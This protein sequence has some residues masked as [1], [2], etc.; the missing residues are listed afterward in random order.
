MRSSRY[1]TC[2]EYR[3]PHPIHCS[4]K[5][6]GHFF[7]LSDESQR[8][9]SAEDSESEATHCYSVQTRLVVVE[10]PR[11]WRSEPRASSSTE[12]VCERIA[13]REAFILA[14]EKRN[15]LL[16][17]VKDT[18]LSCFPSCELLTQFPLDSET[19]SAPAS[20]PIEP[21]TEKFIKNPKLRKRNTEIH[22]S[23]NGNSCLSAKLKSISDRYLKCPTNRLFSKLYKEEKAKPKN[24]RRQRSF[25]YGSL[26]GL[27]IK[28]RENPLF[29]DDSVDSGLKYDTEDGDSGII[30]TD[31][32]SLVDSSD[33]SGCHARSAS[34]EQPSPSSRT[35]LYTD[36]RYNLFYSVL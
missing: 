14:R 36:S 8:Q 27:E 23:F 34:G 15:P 31:T 3:S 24:K 22:E 13:R 33:K 5:Q 25:S 29:L 2:N 11:R 20:T 30:V 1:I 4:F 6:L 10:K 17:H 26:P 32:S 7:F 28:D 35:R 9:S 18:R 12:E 19:P 21:L 16:D